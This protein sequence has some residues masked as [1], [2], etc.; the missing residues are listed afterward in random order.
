[1]GKEL[2]DLISKKTPL[3]FGIR[4]IGTLDNHPVVDIH[5]I[6]SVDVLYKE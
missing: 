6:I 4:S 5:K 1:M 2:Q 3:R